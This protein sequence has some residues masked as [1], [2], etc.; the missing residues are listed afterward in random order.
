MC[1]KKPG[2]R[3]AGHV[4]K[5]RDATV[6]ALNAVDREIS[7]RIREDATADLSDLQ[8]H[9]WALRQDMDRLNDEW[10]ETATGRE[11]LAANM[12]G[13]TPAE[14]RESG[15]PARLAA[16]QDRY[17]RKMA[18]LN[19]TKKGDTVG[20]G[21]ALAYGAHADWLR[22]AGV[23]LDG[24]GRIQGDAYFREGT[25]L[26]IDDR[27]DEVTDMD[28]FGRESTVEVT[29]LTVE[30]PIG[31]GP[32]AGTYLIPATR[33]SDA[34]LLAADDSGTIT[35]AYSYD[36]AS[37]S[38]LGRNMLP[39]FASDMGYD[40]DDLGNYGYGEDVSYTESWESPEIR[41]DANG[42]PRTVRFTGELV[43]DPRD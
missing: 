27:H 41:R 7:A 32:M 5:Q 31:T 23:L 9:K 6:A 34:V 14:L 35:A 13:L 29:N 40:D 26:T 21:I 17:E 18:A 16:A 4:G 36:P 38:S 28:R 2:P 19:A 3:C 33:D 22:H 30:H 43:R 11:A 39:T 15:L 8:A 20:A 42:T 25:L 1:H 12:E 24:R 10:D 37:G